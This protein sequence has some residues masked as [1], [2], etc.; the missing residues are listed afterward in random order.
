MNVSRTN[1][2]I[3][4][5]AVLNG[6]SGVGSAVAPLPGSVPVAAQNRHHSVVQPATCTPTVWA[7]HSGA[8]YGYTAPN[9]PPCVTLNGSY[10]GL[11][12]GSPLGVAMGSTPNYLYVADG[13]NKRIV[14]F[15]AQGNYVKWLDTQLA[16]TPYEP[17]G[18]CVSSSGIVGVATIQEQGNGNVEFFSPNALTGS[19]PTGSAAGVRDEWCAFDSAGNF[20]VDGAPAMPGQQIAYLASAYVNLPGQTL[21]G[22]GLSSPASYV[23]MYSRINSPADQTL[24]VATVVNHSTTQRVYTWNVSG[25]ATGPLS[26]TPASGS[27]YAFTTYPNHPRWDPI[28]GVAP[29]AGGASGT[30]FFADLGKGRV[31]QAPANG[32]S[33]ATYKSLSHTIG[34]ATN[35]TGQY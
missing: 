4:A 32:G 10:A 22:T 12:L 5:A 6:C 34:V 15:D 27:P 21:V 20:F 2:I 9:S 13:Y 1:L 19:L 26:F 14:V 7:L 24:S 11:P 30:L 25:A 28:D 17:W 29:S 3:C 31:L 23:G 33:I 35:P 8:V 18:V 16:G